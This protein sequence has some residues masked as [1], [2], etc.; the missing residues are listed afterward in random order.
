[1]TIGTRLFTLLRGQLIGMDEFGNRYYQDR[2]AV[3]GQRRKRW[4]MYRGTAEASRVPA[5]WHRWLHY[6]TDKSPRDNK[7][8]YSWEKP[9]L[10]NLTGTI[11]AYV[12][13]GHMRKGG[14][15]Y[16][17]SADYEPWQP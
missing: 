3:A 5:R 9:H 14:R 4:V 1:M 7:P 13:E 8:L 11:H 6:I 15:R 10:P 2:K 12:P 16:Q 17:V